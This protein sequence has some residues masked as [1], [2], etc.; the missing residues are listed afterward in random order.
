MPAKIYKVKLTNQERE[1]LK[2][3][4]SKGRVA[5]RK[6]THARILLLADESCPDG[7]KKDREIINVL[8]T[9]RRTVGRVR[10]RFVEEG[11]ESALHA[12]SRTNN[13]PRKLDGEAE[14]FLVATACSKAP[15]GRS[16]WTLQ[17]LSD[18]LVENEIVNS[19][20]NET[21]R[22]TLKKTRLNHG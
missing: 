1:Q 19:I 13:R 22:Q 9:S 7:A 4:V 11:L 15:E 21:V 17:L 12:K 6:Q 8:S 5:A 20:S 16:N 14:A 10:Q 18:R 3:L 2:G